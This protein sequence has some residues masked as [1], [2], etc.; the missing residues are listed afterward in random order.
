MNI[1]HVFPIAVALA[2]DAFAVSVTAGMA[3]GKV[4]ARQ[5]RK[6]ALYFGTFQGGMPVI[7]W[8]AGQSVRRYMAALDHWIAFGLLLAIGLKMLLDSLR[9][10]R[11]PD[12]EEVL[13]PTRMLLLSMATSVDALAVGVTFAMLG[14]EIWAACLVIGIVT[15]VLC[16]VGIE[17]GEHGGARLGRSAQ[18]LGGALLCL[19]GI[20][21][22]L[23]HLT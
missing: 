9:G 23:Q 1:F 3:L 12:P 5:R 14:V 6:V 13:R 8:L 21:I 16:A 10:R 4:T 22:L 19:I 15:G 18:V 20:R 11:L 17:I 7:G 2:M